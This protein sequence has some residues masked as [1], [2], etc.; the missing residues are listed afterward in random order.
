MSSYWYGV[1]DA[2]LTVGV[3]LAACMGV[4]ILI[5]YIRH[6]R[7]ELKKLRDSIDDLW[8]RLGNFSAAETSRDRAVQFDIDI[9]KAKVKALE[10]TH[11]P[12]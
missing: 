8:H 7:I 4:Y 3:V 6:R 1:W 2:V 9:L 5:K 11:S 10:D 12:K